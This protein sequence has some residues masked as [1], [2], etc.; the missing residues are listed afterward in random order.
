MSSTTV[1]LAVYDTLADWEF[2]YA[3]AVLRESTYHRAPRRPVGVRT[4]SLG[5]AGRPSPPSAACGS[6]PTWRWTSCARVT[7]R[8]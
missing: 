8:C 1:H 3:T 2:G 4:V 5:G 6:C 7:A